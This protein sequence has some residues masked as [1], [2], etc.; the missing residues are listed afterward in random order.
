MCTPPPVS[1][2][3]QSWKVHGPANGINYTQT[4]SLARCSMTHVPDDSNLCICMSILCTPRSS[5]AAAA[6]SADSRPTAR[7]M[8]PL[9]CLTMLQFWCPKQPNAFCSTAAAVVFSAFSAL[10]ARTRGH[11]GRVVSQTPRVARKRRRQRQ[12]QSQE[13]DDNVQLPAEH[14][15]L[16]V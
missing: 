9:E 8:K 6:A 14:S 3:F 11:N 2:G 5:G 16:I 1:C 10:V 4:F 13:S 12:M 7:V 15:A